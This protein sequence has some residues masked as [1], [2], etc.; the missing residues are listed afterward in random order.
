MRMPPRK[1]G[2]I[3]SI[4]VRLKFTRTSLILLVTERSI[5][6]LKKR[7]L[8]RTRTVRDVET[9][10][11]IEPSRFSVMMSQLRAPFKTTFWEDVMDRDDSEQLVDLKLLSYAYLEAGVIEMLGA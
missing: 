3:F 5:L 1:P 10:E 9:N 6:S 2:K 4:I 8:R 11:I 7:A